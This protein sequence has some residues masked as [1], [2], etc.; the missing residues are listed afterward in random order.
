MIGYHLTCSAL[1]QDKVVSP[2][3]SECACAAYRQI[4]KQLVN[5]LVLG[6]LRGG[7]HVSSDEQEVEAVGSSNDVVDV[8]DGRDLGR[9][10]SCAVDMGIRRLAEAHQILHGVAILFTIVRRGAA[11]ADVQIC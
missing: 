8:I 7:R 6:Q 3:E 1:S 5:L 10:T 4:V 2:T 9:D 11:F